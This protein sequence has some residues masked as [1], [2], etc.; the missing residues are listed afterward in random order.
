MCFEREGSGQSI[1]RDLY[2]QA[3]VIVQQALYFDEQLPQLP[4]VYI[5]SAGGPVVEGDEY[6][7][8]IALREN[9]CAHISSGAATKVARM[10]GGCA[11]LRQRLS[12]AEGSYVEYLPEPTI[13]CLGA[14]YKVECE[15]VVAPSATLFYSDI[16]MS[17]RLHSG[18]RYRYERLDLSTRI[19][20]PDGG[21]LFC[22]RQ[23][24]EPAVGDVDNLAVMGGAEIFATALIVAPAD[25]SS[26]LY[27]SITPKMGHDISLGVHILPSD[28]GI[29]CRI[30]GRESGA[31]KHQ[32]RELCSLLRQRLYGVGLPAEF[33]WR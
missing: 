18:E 10:K 9:S 23:V 1:L 8:K 28:A 31:V 12:L 25:V 17:G 32:I 7:Y 19:L 6:D 24:V 16:F 13:P 27:D 4:C 30:V 11:R 22:E 14:S 21:L 5:L 2:R 26:A 29:V 3:P 33:P 15:A 20:R